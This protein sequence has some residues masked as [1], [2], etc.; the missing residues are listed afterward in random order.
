MTKYAAFLRGVNVGGVNLKMA[1]VAA[2]LTEA[3]FTEVRTILATGNVRLESTAGVAAGGRSGTGGQ[4]GLPGAVACPRHPGADEL[5]H[6]L[7]AILRLRLQHRRDLVAQ[8]G[9]DLGE[10]GHLLPRLE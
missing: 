8:L 5:L 1:E 10:I 9:G 2:A 7:R 3:G 6:R 4:P